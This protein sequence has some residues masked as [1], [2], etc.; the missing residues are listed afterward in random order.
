MDGRIEMESHLYDAVTRIDQ[1]LAL[2][3]ELPDE[4]DGVNF[5]TLNGARMGIQRV[6]YDSLARRE[7]RGAQWPA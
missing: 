4:R 3:A 1:A 7:R 6:V 2:L 5:N